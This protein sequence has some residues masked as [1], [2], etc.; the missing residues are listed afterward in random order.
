[1][2]LVERYLDIAVF[3]EKTYQCAGVCK[4]ADKFIFTDLT[5]GKPQ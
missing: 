1:M 4:P 5:K 2:D 3:M